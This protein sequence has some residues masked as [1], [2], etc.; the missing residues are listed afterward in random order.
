MSHR[1]SRDVRLI[2]LAQPDALGA[3]HD[4]TIGT[5]RELVIVELIDPETGTSGWGECSALNEPGYTSEWARGA[6]DVLTAGA[7]VDPADH[8]Q[9]AAALE[10]ARIDLD[11]RRRSQSLL[12][13]LAIDAAPVVAGATIG[14][15]RPDA[16]TARALDLVTAGYRRLK[17]KIAPDH[18]LAIVADVARA[19]PGVEIHVDANGSFPPAAVDHLA[20]I[21][22][23]VAVFEQPFAIDD[24]DS[25]RTLR[26]RTEAKVMA[27][28][29]ARPG[30]R[31][32]R[33]LAAR[34]VDG[35]A[36]KPGC[37]GG[38]RAAASTIER[39]GE[40]GLDVSIGGM[41][42]SG[43]GRHVL[44]ALAAHKAVTVVGDVSPAALWL[45]DDPW[46]DL[47]LVDGRVSPHAG[48]GVAPAPDLAV[49]ERCTVTRR[50]LSA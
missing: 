13:L 4:T 18:D 3:A 40:A 28:E 23:D 37:V 17:L 32:D 35:I 43:L 9:A 31:L 41:L 34:A 49:L 50:R 8:P 38:I 24:L 42:E 36:V 20:A 26:E 1:P 21:D 45:R 11:L 5:Q 30:H 29:G 7:P 27:D 15:G 47:G 33:L 16:V 48:T 6:Y 25:S 2:S 44:A 10:M 12:E 14:L 46:P 39:C 22:G 19:H